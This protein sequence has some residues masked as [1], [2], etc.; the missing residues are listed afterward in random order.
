MLIG[1]IQAPE[2]VRATPPRSVVPAADPPVPATPPQDVP[3]STGNE[4][5]SQTAPLITPVTTPTPATPPMPTTTVTPP[6]GQPGVIRILWEHFRA[7]PSAQL[8]Q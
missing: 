2:D 1:Q 6:T 8:C 5:D 4:S 3:E 7:D